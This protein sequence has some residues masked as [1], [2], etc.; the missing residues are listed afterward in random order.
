MRIC[1]LAAALLLAPA[2]AWAGN[3]NQPTTIQFPPNAASATIDSGPPTGTL[4]CYQIVGRTDQTLTLTL[5][6]ASDD[7]VLALYAPGW[8]AKCNDAGDCELTG[9]LLSEADISDWSDKL[10]VSGA[11]LIVIDS[12][13]SDSDYELTV[14][15]Q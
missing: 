15:M 6:S 10:E 8:S 9:D 14:E 2:A 4:D 13:K 1:T 3:C 11:Y 12:S 5:E 7:A